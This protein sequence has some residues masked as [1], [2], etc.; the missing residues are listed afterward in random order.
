MKKFASIFLVAAMA[1]SLVACGGGDSSSAST[2]T[3]AAGGSS[4]AA[5]TP[6]EGGKGK[7]AYIVGNLGDTPPRPTSTRTASW[8]LWIRA[9]STSSA[10]PP[11]W[12]S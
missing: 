8:T 5:S 12:R 2:S 9:T 1:L 3:P 4:T 7:I 11:I 10:P 6:A